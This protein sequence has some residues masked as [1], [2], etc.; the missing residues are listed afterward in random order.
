MMKL[1]LVDDQSLVQQGVATLLEMSGLVNVVATLPSGQALIDWLNRHPQE[2]D[3]ILLDFHMPAL[4]GI[5]T[6]KALP[7]RGG[8]PV[9]FLSTFADAALSREA[10]RNGAAGWLAKSIEINELLDAL[11]LAVEGQRVFPA[12]EQLPEENDLSAR[13]FEVARCLVEGMTNQQIADT[14]HLS[15]GTVKNYTSNLFSKLEVENRTQAIAALRA[16]GIN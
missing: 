10:R 1:V 4:D 14:C 16:R 15:L 12:L 6:L 11:S 3:L 13:E 8:I 5:E 2:C 9:I 7:N